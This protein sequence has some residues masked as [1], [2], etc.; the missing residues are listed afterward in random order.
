MKNVLK[1]IFTND[2]FWFCIGYIISDLLVD[3]VFKNLKNIIVN[4]IDK[5]WKI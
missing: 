3:W 5:R 2:I 4:N 1:K